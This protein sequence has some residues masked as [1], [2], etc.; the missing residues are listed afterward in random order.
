MKALFQVLL[1]ANKLFINLEKTVLCL[2]L[3]SMAIL[4]F[5]QVVARN[6]FSTG[7]VWAT[8]VIRIEV[9]WI[10]LIGAALATEYRQ[11]IKIDILHNLLKS[12]KAK[13]IVDILSQVFAMLICFLLFVVG[14]NYILAV[15]SITTA[16]MI[17]GVP[18]WVFKLII[19][20]C[21]LMMS[22]RCFFC[23]VKTIQGVDTRE[24]EYSESFEDLKAATS[25][26]A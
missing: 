20:Y 24:S 6:F 5:G 1:N 9:L 8:E 22:V 14:K 3:F 12:K 11:H 4:S 2:L 16:T 21:F 13:Q 15:S 7:F 10:T 18:D 26:K 17:Q 23:I 25:E 19:P